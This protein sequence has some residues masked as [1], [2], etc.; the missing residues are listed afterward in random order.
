MIVVNRCCFLITATLEGLLLA[1]CP[2]GACAQGHDTVLTVG[3][4]QSRFSFVPTLGQNLPAGWR[5]THHRSSFVDSDSSQLRLAEFSRGC[6]PQSRRI[7]SRSEA[8]H[9]TSKPPFVDDH[10]FFFAQENSVNLARISSSCASALSTEF[11][12]QNLVS[13]YYVTPQSFGALFKGLSTSVIDTVAFNAALATGR[14][15]EYSFAGGSFVPSGPL[16]IS[17][18]GQVIQCLDG[19]SACQLSVRTKYDPGVFNIKAP[20]VLLS[21]VGVDFLQPDV[22]NLARIL[23]Y[24]P[25]VYASNQPALKIERGRWTNCWT[26]F[27]MSNGNSGNSRIIDNEASCYYSCTFIDGALDTVRSRGNHYWPFGMTSRQAEL[28]G[29]YSTGYLLGRVD[30][31]QSSGDMFLNKVGMRITTSVQ[32]TSPGCAEADLDNPEFD[33]KTAIISDCSSGA[34]VKVS[35]GFASVG[36]AVDSS[37][38]VITG[39]LTASAFQFFHGYNPSIG[40]KSASPLVDVKGTGDFQCAACRFDFYGSAD[41]AA[42]RVNGDNPASPAIA[43]IVGSRVRRLAGQRYKSPIWEIIGKSSLIDAYGN[44]VNKTNIEEN[45]C[46]SVSADNTN[47]VVGNSCP[48]FTQFFPSSPSI[49]VYQ[50]N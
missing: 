22:D 26:C 20:D 47:R 15:L 1:W 42:V 9:L 11:M 7:H 19:R 23:H 49:G 14:T 31:F 25:A 50:F 28:F 21:G 30:N 48:N 34:N 4:P 27:D 13:S 40:S 41:A 29:R 24:Q 45:I 36:S 38:V 2:R 12:Y 6:G 32:A 10:P 35:A 46:F 44:S 5:Y 3:T 37:F 17:T 18:R 33:G 39:T 16:N 8:G 43:T